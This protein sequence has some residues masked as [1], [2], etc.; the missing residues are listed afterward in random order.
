LKHLAILLVVMSALAASLNVCGAAQ[1]QLRARGAFL[2]YR[3]DSVKSLVQQVRTN[4]AV[5]LRYAK[6]FHMSTQS[7]ADFFDK[8]LNLVTLKKP[9]KSTIY[10]VRDGKVVS[11]QRLLPAGSRVFATKGGTI[12]LE[13]RCGN[14]L[15]DKLPSKPVVTKTAGLTTQTTLPPDTGVIT[16]PTPAVVQPAVVPDVSVPAVIT[17]VV[18][19]AAIYAPP[20][21]DAA[22]APVA[23]V[24][25]FVS[26]IG[27]ILPLFLGGATLVH[28]DNSKPPPV[29]EPASLPALAFALTGIG[30]AWRQRRR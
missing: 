4:P 12:V 20:V 28:K 13:W 23:S 2:D 30:F 14:P 29:P 24:P 1:N 9:Q 3:V 19:E 27:Y 26:P 5:G 16:V 22:T 10:Y 11:G 25:S 7:V 15:T 18:P 21:V 8:N 17:D 6:H